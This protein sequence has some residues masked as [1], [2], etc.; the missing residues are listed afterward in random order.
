MT[1]EEIEKYY[2]LLGFEYVAMSRALFDNDLVD[3]EWREEQ[4]KNFFARLAKEH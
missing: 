4:R 1:N 2:E 3:D